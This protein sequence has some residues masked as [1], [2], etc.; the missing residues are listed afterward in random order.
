MYCTQSAFAAR[1]GSD[2]FEQLLP[3]D[4]DRTYAVAASDAD[5]IVD[6]YLAARYAVPLSSVPS[7][8]VGIA[9]D[10]TRHRLY[11]EA[12]PKEVEARRKLA[13]ELL[14]QLRDGK[15]LLPGLTVASASSQSVAV[16]SR[17]AVF[18]EDVGDSFV[19]CL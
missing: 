4:G 2:E 8:I 1:F 7:I 18:T 12:P 6:G 9:A 10:L 19:G 11:D 13:L 3:E 15:L 16:S 17:T 14:E 5:G